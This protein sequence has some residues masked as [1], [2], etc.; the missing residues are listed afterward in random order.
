MGTFPHKHLKKGETFHLIKGKMACVIFKNNGK[1]KFA[2]TLY[3]NDIFRTPINVYHTQIPLTDYVIYHESTLGPFKK[4][5]SIDFSK[6][7]GMVL[8]GVEYV[9]TSQEG[10]FKLSRGPQRPYIKK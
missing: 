3:P 2:F 6:V 8:P 7:L 1:V 5:N 10:I 9:P 4:N